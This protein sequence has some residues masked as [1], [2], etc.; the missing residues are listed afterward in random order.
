MAGI[1]RVGFRNPW[2]YPLAAEA[3]KAE[4]SKMTGEADKRAG[5]LRKTTADKKTVLDSKKIK[6]VEGISAC[7]S[8]D[9]ILLLWPEIILSFLTAL[10]LA[11]YVKFGLIAG[12]LLASLG[13]ILGIYFHEMH[14]FVTARRM[15]LEKKF[16]QYF[17]SGVGLFHQE[18]MR[19]IRNEASSSYIRVNIG[20]KGIGVVYPGEALSKK[21]NLK[22]RRSGSR[23]NIRLLI[24]FAILGI[25]F[26]LAFTI[27]AFPSFVQGAFSTFREGTE[28]NKTKRNKRA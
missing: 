17:P 21:E 23:A 24:T 6:P 8:I 19:A 13:V 3:A 27:I 25:F 4:V 26:H 11:L 18:L 16:H 10:I 22:V 15:I 5:Q 12:F 20:E 9:I 28:K 14:H 7:R 1:E 2:L